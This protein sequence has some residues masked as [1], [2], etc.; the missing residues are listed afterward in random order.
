MSLITDDEVP[1]GGFGE[2][3]LQVFV[4]GEYVKA[5]DKPVAIL[6]RIP[7]PGV[8]DHVPGQDIELEV[9]LLAEFIL[10]LLDEAARSHNQATLQVAAGDQF[11]DQQPG[12]DR[13][14]STGIVGEQESK[15]LARQHLAI[16]RGDLV[17]RRIDQAGVD[18]EI[19]IEI[20]RQFYAVCLT[21]QTQKAAVSVE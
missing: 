9:E 18:G 1:F 3:L 8:L 2:L 7:R 17:R 21:C 13:L 10:P 6:K 15:R 14:P 4:A 16:D 19:G 12:H 20:V 5:N 11:L